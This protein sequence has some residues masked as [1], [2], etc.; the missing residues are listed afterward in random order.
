[1]DAG[2]DLSVGQ[3]LVFKW[4]RS[5]GLHGLDENIERLSPLVF[6]HTPRL[7]GWAFRH[8]DNQARAVRQ[9]RIAPQADLSVVH[10]PLVSNQAHTATSRIGRSEERRVG[11]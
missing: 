11:K 1:M 4:G 2:V 6:S 9:A 3:G 10:K 8:N 5:G 7:P